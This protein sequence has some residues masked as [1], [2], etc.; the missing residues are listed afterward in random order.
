MVFILL[1]VLLAASMA[2][3]YFL[4][5]EDKVKQTQQSE[6]QECITQLNELIVKK[7]K[8]REELVTQ[9]KNEFGVKEQ[10]SNVRLEDLK[11]KLQESQEAFNK[12]EAK[13]S[14]L[15]GHILKLKK[16]IELSTEMYDGLKVQYEDLERDMDKIQQAAMSKDVPA[17]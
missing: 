14:E 5:Q 11:V 4:M 3:V 2:V 6:A 13:I 16:E 12:D 17:K 10:L 8:Q 7:D 15:E 1:A 9:M